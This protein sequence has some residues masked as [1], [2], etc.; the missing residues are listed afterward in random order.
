[1]LVKINNKQIDYLLIFLFA[2]ITIFWFEDNLIYN[3]SEFALPLNPQH[4]LYRAR[5]VWNPDF[6][7]GVINLEIPRVIRP[8]FFALFSWLGISISLSERIFF[9]LVYGAAGLSMYYLSDTLLG[10]EDRIACFI[11]ALV[12]LFNPYLFLG[13]AQLGYATLPFLWGLFIKCL[14]TNNMKDKFKYS[15]YISILSLVLNSNLPDYSWIIVSLPFIT[16][17]SLYYLFKTHKIKFLSMMFFISICIFVLIN[18]WWFFFYIYYLQLPQ[19]THTIEVVKQSSYGYSPSY[20]YTTF[21]NLFKLFG[22]WAVFSGYKGLSFIPY[23]KMYY[24]LSPIH[25]INYLLPILAFAA[26][27]FCRK[28]E[29]LLFSLLTLVYL[30]LA[31][32]PTPPIGKYYFNLSSIQFFLPVRESYKFI[33]GVIITYAYLIGITCQTLYG[34][35][36]RCKYKMLV[37]FIF[38]II[39]LAN[40]YPLVTGDVLTYWNN[41][42]HRGES[43]P[44]SYWDLKR[45]LEGKKEDFR[46]FIVPP[47][48]WEATTWGHYGSS[49][50]T[51]ILP[52]SLI[53]GAPHVGYGEE[54][55]LTQDFIKLVYSSF[56]SNKVP[57]K[58]LALLNIKYI[59]VNGYF[60]TN[61]VDFPYSISQH[62]KI[63]NSTKEVSLE[64]NF[65]ELTLYK[66]NEWKRSMRIYAASNI[67]L[68]SG[69]LNEMSKVIEMDNFTLEESV[70][71]LSSQLTPQQLASL[72]ASLFSSN[73]TDVLLTYRKVDP[74]K[75]VVHVNASRPFFL[76]F[77]E[78][79][80]KDWIAYVNGEQLPDVRHFMANG[81]ANA[82]Y[83]DKPGSYEIILEFWPQRLFYIGA[84]IS[85][86]TFFFCVLYLSKDRMKLLYLRYLKKRKA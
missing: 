69:D 22:S 77:S 20:G 51:L 41:P 35:S 55:P 14:E 54:F 82:W 67:V 30:F 15:F 66:N 73:S 2:S 76:V 40:S 61:F 84:A 10:K 26:V 13:I 80:H 34:K 75:Y 78:S 64:K 62:L 46:V 5:Y 70:L 9:V 43:I 24:S 19:F 56:Y 32:G 39:I 48:L 16:I 86:T 4:Q 25:F 52:S 45:F 65:G 79:Y 44:E 71:L 36:Y 74:T 8:A 72:P 12:Y 23:I 21:L 11:S 57:C 7:A 68:I 18:S 27:L 83:I 47:A 17:F 59:L 3:A 33:V 28:R 38:I 6:E 37:P 58:T 63:L 81:Y 60:D 42:P 53:V 31:K 50:L 49:T 29:V 1:L 85:L